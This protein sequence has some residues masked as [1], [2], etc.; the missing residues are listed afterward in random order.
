MI[1]FSFGP[2]QSSPSTPLI[3]SPCPE[4]ARESRKGTRIEWMMVPGAA[5]VLSGMGQAE[6]SSQ[7]H[8]K[9]EARKEPRY[10]PKWLPDRRISNC[11][12]QKSTGKPPKPDTFLSLS[13]DSALL[14]SHNGFTHAQAATHVG[15]ARVPAASTGRSSR[16]CDSLE[17]E[18]L[19]C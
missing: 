9:I 18:S 2:D 12:F 17:F 14:L 1:P 15:D 6:M 13:F 16:V 11:F 3:P 7:D 5:R 10:P 8:D 19:H 4:E